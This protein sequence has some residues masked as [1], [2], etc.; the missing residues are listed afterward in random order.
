MIKKLYNTESFESKYTKYHELIYRT[1][2]QYL[3]DIDTAEDITQEV[4]VKLFTNTKK[5]ND[6]EHEKAWILRVTYNLCKNILKSKNYTTLQLDD[7]LIIGN[8]SFEN[9]TT[10]RLDLDNSL[11]ILTNDQRVCVYLHYYLS[12]TT[13]EISELLNLNENTIKSH[14]KRSRRIL[15]DS[16]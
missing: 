15:R 7:D 6:D 4:F 3:L 5:F 8:N 12:Y 11:K 1:A 2:Y 14:L 9:Q 13:K 16:I 10:E